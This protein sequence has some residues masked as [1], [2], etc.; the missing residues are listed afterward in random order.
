MRVHRSLEEM[1]ERGAILRDTTPASRLNRK[2]AVGFVPTMGALHEAHLALIEASQAECVFT[3]VSIY[4]NPT[5]FGPD[6]DLD[7][8]PRQLE[9]DMRILAEAG[10]DSVFLPTNEQMYPKGFR[11]FLH[12]DGI[13]E[14]PEA[15]A[16]ADHFRGVA[17][18]CSKL[19]NLVRPNMVYIGQKDALQCVV[20]RALVRDYNLDMGVTVCPIVREIDGLAMRCAISFSVSAHH[21]DSHSCK[22]PHP[23]HTPHVTPHHT[24][25]AQRVSLRR[26]AARRHRP[27]L[28]AFQGEQRAEGRLP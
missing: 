13:E 10:V 9:R 8:Y 7:A 18:V 11:T 4:V 23:R 21:H 24:Q 26:S 1:R 12:Y 27:V 5:Q 16:R 20:L 2:Y 14:R 3:V 6:E 17:T 19:F 15:K 28:V 25:L 22:P